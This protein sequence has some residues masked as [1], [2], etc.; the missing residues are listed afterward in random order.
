MISELLNFIDHNV[1]KEKVNID[2]FKPELVF[3]D[4]DYPKDKDKEIVLEIKDNIV[5][6]SLVEKKRIDFSGADELFY[7][8]EEA[9]AYLMNL[10]D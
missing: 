4:I 2:H 1:T 10:L 7:S 9:Q 6:I 8:L 5:G 3:V